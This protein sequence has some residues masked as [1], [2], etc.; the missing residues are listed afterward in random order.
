MIR[1]LGGWFAILL[2]AAS[3]MAQQI[4]FDNS[5]RVRDLMRSGNLYLS[6][7]DGLA[8]A[9]ENN[10]DIELQRFALPQG[11]TELLRARGGGV[12][13][14]LNY[15]LQEAPTGVGGPLSLLAVNR[16]NTGTATAGASVATNASELGALGE[17]PVNLSMQGTVPQSNGTAV[18][19]F[20]PA[21]VGLVN[22]QH[23]TTPQTNYL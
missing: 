10:L 4:R 9:I 11:D 18:P 7:Q 8:L 6:L 22:W 14:G 20:D 12:T 16:A 23:Q 1:G 17:P 3:G 19:I 15:T 13:R 5:Q 2:C 21:I